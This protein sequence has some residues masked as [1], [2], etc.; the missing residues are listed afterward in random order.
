MLQFINNIRSKQGFVDLHVHTNDSYGEEMDLMNLTPEEL[1]E[2]VYQYTQKYDNCPV[3]FAVTDHNSIEAV[4]KIKQIIESD[5]EKYAHINFISGCEFSCSA[6]SLG[7]FTNLNGYTRN[8]AKNFHMLAYNF[9]ENNED[10]KFITN[11]YSTRR[12][13]TILC[14]NIYISAGSFVIATQN[15]LKDHN[16]ILPIT[17]FKDI[18]LN[19]KKTSLQDFVKEIVTYCE[20]FNISEDVK[21]DIETQL[22]SRNILHLGKLDCMEIMEIVENAGGSCVLAH[23]YITKLSNWAKHNATEFE[24]FVDEKLRENNIT[25]TPN[26]KAYDKFLKYMIYTLKYKAV[27]PTTHKKLKGLIGIETLHASC[28]DRPYRLSNLTKFAREYNLYMTCGGDS[29]GNLIRSS[30]LSRFIS[31]CSCDDY[32]SNNVVATK[33]ALATE[34]I[35]GITPATRDCRLSF[36][37]QFRIIKTRGEEVTELDYDAFRQEI[38]YPT[39]TSRANFRSNINN[40]TNSPTNSTTSRSTNSATTSR[41]STPA[42]TTVNSTPHTETSTTEVPKT[43]SDATENP[44]DEVLNIIQTGTNN[45]ITIN[46][47]LQD[48]VDKNYSPQFAMEKYRSLFIYKRAITLALKNTRSNKPMLEDNEQANNFLELFKL[49]KKLSKQFRKKYEKAYYSNTSKKDTIKED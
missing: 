24:Q 41:T 28:F 21:K 13:N 43:L 26:L 31:A 16:I 27:S 3:T 47:V 36:N 40:I 2:S 18:N 22:I 14:N 29:H 15:I 32:F 45:I 37:Q 9:D 33:C 10:I 12:A 19:T 42:N 4:R 5:K 25:T 6:G 1:L 35:K 23:P 11:L 39:P 34:L 30:M 38:V 44:L 17:E 8:I 49:N 48:L 46:N 7:T 20:K